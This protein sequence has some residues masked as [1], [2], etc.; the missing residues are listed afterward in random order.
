MERPPLRPGDPL[1]Y[2]E[3]LP[4]WE[5]RG[6]VPIVLRNYWIYEEEAGKA[7]AEP[8]RRWPRACGRASRACRAR[9]AVRLKADETRL[10]YASGVTPPAGLGKRI[11]LDLFSLDG[12]IV[13]RMPRPDARHGRGAPE[14]RTPTRFNL[15]VREADG[16]WLDARE[17]LDDGAAAA[18]HHGH[19]REAEDDHHPQQ[20]A[21]HRLRPLDQSPIAAAS[22][23]A[24]IASPGRPTPS[25]ISRR[26]SISRPSCSPSPTRRRLL[27]EE[28]A[29][30]GYRVR[31]IAMGTN[32][33]PYQ[34][35]EA[36]WRI[37]RSVLEVLAET[38]HPVTI[39]T[40]SDRV[41]RDLDIL[42]P[43]AAQGLAVG[44]AVG[45]LADA[46]NLAHAR[47]ARAVGAQAAG[48][49]QGAERGRRPGLRRDRAGHPRHHRPRARAYRRGRGRGRA[50]SA[51]SSC[52]CGCP[53]RSRRCSAPGSTSIS[54]TAPTR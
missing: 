11:V 54:P 18:A 44:R 52:R 13:A 14:N 5:T 2:I 32:T 3:S 38:R 24:S 36:K 45:D 8:R 42:A 10:A 20:L 35:I 30:P 51:P 33:D 19:G 4:Y 7:G 15:P 47:A 1:L 39:T 46:G 49:G 9:R 6:Y 43:M 12:V 23:A 17:E 34:P 26:A 53:T 22:M 41:L 28:L 40:K 25:T 27:R 16:D 31:P 21:R 48:G 50:R 29:K 37:T